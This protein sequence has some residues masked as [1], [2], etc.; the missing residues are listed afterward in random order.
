MRARRGGA[1]TQRRRS[2]P[3]IGVEPATAGSTAPALELDDGV[4]V[5]ERF[6]T[7]AEDVFAAGDVARFYDPVFGYAP[8]DRALVE[9]ELPGRRGRE[10]P[11]RRRRGY[12]TVSSFFTELFGKAFRVFGELRG[13]T[14]IEGSFESGRAIVRYRPGAG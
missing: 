2:S 9:R 3:G 4:V 11:R 13:E 6:R 7:S 12:D 5:D 8:P 1:A 10:D 14:E